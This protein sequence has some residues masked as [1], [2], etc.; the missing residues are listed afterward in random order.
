MTYHIIIY[1]YIYINIK[2]FSQDMDRFEIRKRI[3]LVDF[4]Q[5][6]VIINISIF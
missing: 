1:I 6:K 5:I 4:I 3:I 2:L